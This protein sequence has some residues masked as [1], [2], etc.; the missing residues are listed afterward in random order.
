ME[1]E[2]PCRLLSEMWG[3]RRSGA[4]A[5]LPGRR[6]WERTSAPPSAKHGLAPRASPT[7]RPDLEIE[8]R[9]ALRLDRH[10]DEYRIPRS[11]N[12]SQVKP[13]FIRDGIRRTKSSSSFPGPPG[14]FAGT[15]CD[16]S[17]RVR[18]FRPLSSRFCPPFRPATKKSQAGLPGLVRH[19]FEGRLLLAALRRGR[20]A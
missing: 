15:P 6:Y 1:T 4:D 9:T 17:V 3:W 11:I 13:R 7:S 14:T 2:L 12:F 8:F 19:R 5:Y 16:D 10:A 18:R 20:G